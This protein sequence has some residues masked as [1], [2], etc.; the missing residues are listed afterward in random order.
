L[1][2]ADQAVSEFTRAARIASTNVNPSARAFRNV[3][4]NTIN[5]RIF[6]AS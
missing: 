3:R 6:V 1:A 4:K 2:K 5:L